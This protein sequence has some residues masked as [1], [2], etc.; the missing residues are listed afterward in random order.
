MVKGIRLRDNDEALVSPRPF[1]V[2]TDK[3]NLSTIRPITRSEAWPTATANSPVTPSRSSSESAETGKVA[4]K[5]GRTSVTA[6]LAAKLASVEPWRCPAPPGAP[7][8]V[9]RVY[10]RGGQLELRRLLGW[11]LQEMQNVVGGSSVR[12][13]LLFDSNRN[14]E[15]ILDEERGSRSLTGQK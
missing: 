13:Q 8:P 11:D 9:A 14:Q 15:V 2:Y 10:S 5:T 3:Q 7:P 1:P 6:Q 4:T 12:N